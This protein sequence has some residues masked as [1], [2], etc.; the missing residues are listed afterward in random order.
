MQYWLISLGITS[1]S[2]FPGGSEDKASACNAGDLGSIPGLERSPGEGNG[3][4]FQ[5]SYLENPMDR[6][7]YRA[8]VHR[9]A[10]SQTQ[11]SDFTSLTSSRTIHVIASDRITFFWRLNN[12]PLCIYTTC[13]YAC[14]VTSVVS[15]SCDLMDCNSP[16]P[17]V[18]G[19]LQAWIQEWVAMLSSRGSSQPGYQTN[20]CLCLLHC[21]WT[22]SPLSQ[23]GS[24]IYHIVKSLSHVWLFV[25]PWTVAYQAPP[26]MGFSRQECWSGLPFP[27]PDIPHKIT[28][29][30][31]QLL[32]K[33]KFLRNVSSH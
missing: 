31:T 4:R 22:L 29:I 14:S 3:N 18:H 30:R 7:A 24:P 1:S 5:Y 13:M 6:G 2:S 27:S 25:T 16:G 19:I 32:N 33:W 15:A 11:L 21:Q 17:S 23:L 10:K 20:I 8:T 12:I 28:L 9:V 26:S